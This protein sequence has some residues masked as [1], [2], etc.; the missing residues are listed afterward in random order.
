M[1]FFT[2]VAGLGTLGATGHFG[3]NLVYDHGTGV[4]GAA[5]G[6]RPWRQF[7]K[8]LNCFLEM[9]RENSSG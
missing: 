7:P 8:N 2:K 6:K 3:G 9:S 5:E 1:F 4:T